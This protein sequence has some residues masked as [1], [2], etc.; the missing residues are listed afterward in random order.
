MDFSDVTL[1]NSSE[2]EQLVLKIGFLPFFKNKVSGFSVEEMTP[3][4]FWFDDENDGPWEWKMTIVRNWNCAYGT[5]FGGKSGY[6]SLE[7]Y[8][9][10]INYRR[11]KFSF[12][13]APVDA[14][15]VNRQKYI[16]D[17]VI[18]NESMQSRDIKRACPFVDFPK[19]RLSPQD[20]LL[21]VKKE[22]D[23][24]E[25]FDKVITTLQMSTMLAIADFEYEYDKHGNPYGWGLARYAA[26]EVLYGEHVLAAGCSPEES[27]EKMLTHLKQLLPDANEKD[28]LK[29]LL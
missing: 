10:L 17:M 18:A 27:F 7:W 6:V 13:A 28:L 19:K 23:K 3:R 12:S 11:S 8:P 9:H 22:K 26:P 25:S 20:K 5:L 4:E 1:H 29:M 2:L 15:G 16:Y 14:D 21:G 24:G